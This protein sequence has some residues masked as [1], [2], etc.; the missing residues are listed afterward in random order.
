MLQLSEQV[1]LCHRTDSGL[2]R[3]TGVRRRDGGPRHSNGPIS[4]DVCSETAVPEDEIPRQDTPTVSLVATVLEKGAPQASTNHD[5]PIG[6]WNEGLEPCVLRLDS[7]GGSGVPQ[8]GS[9][10]PF[11]H[12]WTPCPRSV[13]PGPV[14]YLSRPGPILPGRGPQCP[15][16]DK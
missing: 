14:P 9:C 15:P 13:R 1:Q 2:G 5:P 3:G 7:V 4:T 10:L 8:S 11:G 16:H 6:H 12:H